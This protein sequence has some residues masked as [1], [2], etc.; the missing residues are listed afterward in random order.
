MVTFHTSL[1]VKPIDQIWVL[2]IIS[3]LKNNIDLDCLNDLSKNLDDLFDSSDI[4]VEDINS[5]TNSLN[6]IIIKAAVSSGFYN[7]IN[8]HVNYSANQNVKFE[9]DGYKCNKFRKKYR[10]AR[11]NYLNNKSP[12]NKQNMIA[13]STAYKKVLNQSCNS[14]YDKLNNK[15]RSLKTSNTKEF[16]KTLKRNYKTKTDIKADFHDLLEHST[17]TTPDVGVDNN[18]MINHKFSEKEIWDGI[19]KLKNNKACGYDGIVNEFIKDAA[20]V[21]V[22][23]ITKIFNL[24]LNVGLVPYK[25][26]IGI[27]TTIF[28]TKDPQPTPTITEVSQSQTVYFVN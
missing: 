20:D 10:N 18:S 23:V 9:K 16:W 1:T 25:W 27:I 2:T 13:K 21:I 5:I 22:P 7:N 4:V 11:N 3:S 26:S 6:D 24:I 15:L 12:H 8:R 28:K 14:H 19:C 17:A